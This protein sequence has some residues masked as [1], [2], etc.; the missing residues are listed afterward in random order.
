[1]RLTMLVR[2]FLRGLLA[3]LLLVVAVAR[4]WPS[5]P[6]N[7]TR[8]RTPDVAPTA[9]AT[10]EGSRVTIANVRNFKYRSESDYDQRWET[11]TYNLDGIR[12]LDLSLSI[13]VPTQIAHTIVSWEFDNGQYLAISIEP[14][15]RR[16]SHIRRYE[17]SSASTSFIT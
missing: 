10:F 11:R 1:M 2:P 7:N 13:W 6:P 4:W 5:I 3:A 15:R 14:A 12:G 17:A 16:V 9:H 8:D